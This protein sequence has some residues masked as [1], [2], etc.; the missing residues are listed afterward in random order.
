ML[1]LDQSWSMFSPDPPL[2]DGWL[3]IKSTLE[4]REQVNLLNP[5]QPLTREKLDDVAA[6]FLDDR[7]KAY[8]LNLVQRRLPWRGSLIWRRNKSQPLDRR[9]ID[10][11]VVLMQEEASGG[12]SPEIESVLLHESFFE[13]VGTQAATDQSPVASICC[14]GIPV[15]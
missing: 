11:R 14:A 1:R 4:N 5:S 6:S 13:T 10:L 12:S 15:L 7:W 2:D 8:L 3:V 9:I